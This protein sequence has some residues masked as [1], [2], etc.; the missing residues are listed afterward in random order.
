M[1]PLFCSQNIAVDLA[2]P[3]KSRRRLDYHVDLLNLAENN[4]GKMSLAFKSQGEDR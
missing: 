4:A 1:N 2:F 3:V